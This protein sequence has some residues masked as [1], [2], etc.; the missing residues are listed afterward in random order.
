M[1]KHICQNGINKVNYGYENRTVLETAEYNQGYRDLF[2]WGAFC[3]SHE[4]VYRLVFEGSVDAYYESRASYYKFNNLRD[5]NRTT[6]FHALF[7]NTCYPYHLQQSALYQ[8]N[9]WGILYFE[10]LNQTKQIMTS[11]YSVVC[12]DLVCKKGS[13]HPQCL[14]YITCKHQTN[15]FHLYT[16]IYI[17]YS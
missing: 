8:E 16:C 15:K 14:Q 10:E 4:G 12:E 11:E 7:A 2:Y 6:T 3:P 1:V 5:K 17:L 9:N 13:L